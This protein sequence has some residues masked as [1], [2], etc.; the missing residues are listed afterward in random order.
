[1]ILIQNWNKDL[2]KQIERKPVE[3]NTS[4]KAFSCRKNH[5]FFTS[6]FNRRI[7]VYGN[8]FNL[9]EMKLGKSLIDQ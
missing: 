6:Q 1:M 9:F 4:Q 2:K 8:N 3:L 7:N 5:T